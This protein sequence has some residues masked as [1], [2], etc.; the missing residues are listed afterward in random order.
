MPVA[1]GYTREGAVLG[2]TNDEDDPQ[3]V[4]FGELRADG[5]EKVGQQTEFDLFSE[6]RVLYSRLRSRNTSRRYMRRS[7]SIF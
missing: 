3:R 6:A 7:S 1:S 5:Y 4:E 2:L